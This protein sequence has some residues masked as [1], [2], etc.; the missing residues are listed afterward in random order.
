VV[1]PVAGVAPPVVG[2]VVLAGAANSF[3][4]IIV[5]LVAVVDPLLEGVNPS[6]KIFVTA[7]PY[8]DLAGSLLRWLFVKQFRQEL[9]SLNGTVD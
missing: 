3:G 7:G 5:A 6:G 4:V 9:P 1:P 2:A 8:I